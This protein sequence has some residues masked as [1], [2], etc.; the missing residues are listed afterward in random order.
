MA[1]RIDDSKPDDLLAAPQ[2]YVKP[3]DDLTGHRVLLLD[4]HLNQLHGL[5]LDIHGHALY[6]PL[7][8][9]QI[10]MLPDRLVLFWATV[11]V[12]VANSPPVPAL[13]VQVPATLAVGVFSAAACCSRAVPHP[14]ATTVTSISNPIA[15][16][17]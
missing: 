16:V 1:G 13:P 12:T 17:F 14:A 7:D 11:S 6:R 10:V 8:L 15:S 4:E 3:A 5:Q 2:G 9:P